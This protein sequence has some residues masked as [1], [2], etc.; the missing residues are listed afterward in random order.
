ML[1]SIMSLTRV[2]ALACLWQMAMALPFT[3]PF[4]AVPGGGSGSHT[5]VTGDGTPPP[6][7]LTP[8]SLNTV[9]GDS[10]GS[11]CELRDS[12]SW[13]WGHDSMSTSVVNMPRLCI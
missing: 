10:V 2:G 11:G 13:H 7:Y 12:E 8:V 3:G 6:L 5:I 1:S 4:P 9:Y